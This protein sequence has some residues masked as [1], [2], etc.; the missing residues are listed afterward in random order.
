MDKKNGGIRPEDELKLENQLCFHMYASTRGVIRQYKPFLDEIGLTYTQYMTMIVLWE[1]GELTSREIGRLLY[2]VSGTL[3]PLLKRLEDQGLLLRRR[4]EAD[5]RNL[6]VTITEAGE[7]LKTKAL[8]IPAKIR[9]SI[10]LSDEDTAEVR[11]LA[12][13]VL[14]AMK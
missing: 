5:E 3:T 9:S 8:E 11:R 1:H 2:L 12:R 10:E 6:I 7:A 4:S 13:I 14:D